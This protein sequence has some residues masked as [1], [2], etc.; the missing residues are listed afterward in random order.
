LECGV[1]LGAFRVAKHQ[2]VE[3][4]VGVDDHR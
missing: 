2:K 4:D 1:Q 3:H